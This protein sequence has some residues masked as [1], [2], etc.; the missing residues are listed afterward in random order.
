[1]N[2]R[3]V[4]AREANQQ[5][6]ALLASTERDGETIIITRRGKAVARLVPEPAVEED[7][8]ADQL[9]NLLDRYARPMHGEAFSR[10]DLYDRG[11]LKSQ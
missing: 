7:R 10:E 3:R 2:I 11:E 5:F 1:M 9:A 6:S 8:V 4:G